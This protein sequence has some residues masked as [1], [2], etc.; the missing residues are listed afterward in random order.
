MTTVTP[1]DRYACGQDASLFEEEEMK[2]RREQEYRAEAKRAEQ[3]AQEA[4]LRE[5]RERREREREE[6]SNS[7]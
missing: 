7:K 1:D 2:M 3:E 5:E 6:V 4:Q